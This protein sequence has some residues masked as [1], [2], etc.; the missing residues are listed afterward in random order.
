MAVDYTITAFG[1][2]RS[3][4]WDNL[5]SSGVLN[6]N[7]YIADGFIQP[8]VPIIPIQQVPEFNNL[9]G[10]KPYIIYDYDINY[11]DEMWWICEEKVVFSIVSTDFDKIVQIT[12]FMV[13]LFRRM[14]ESAGDLND[15]EPSTT[16]FKFFTIMLSGASSPS[17]S[18]E[19]GGRLMGEVQI[20]YK[21]SRF[22]DENGRFE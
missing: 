11:V 15:V 14:D 16:K 7:D 20:T 6:S 8:L 3:F 17:P 9:I 10:N 18:D 12:Q 5:K 13:D 21:Y 19:E 2:I 22:L 1:K 4:L